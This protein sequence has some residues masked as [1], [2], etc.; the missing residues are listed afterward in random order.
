[1]LTWYPWESPHARSL[2]EE[3]ARREHI[4]KER[5]RRDAARRSDADAGP[6]SSQTPQRRPQNGQGNAGDEYAGPH[7]TGC[8]CKRRA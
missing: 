6:V 8:S 7:C 5:A 1:V 2:R 3:A 4:R